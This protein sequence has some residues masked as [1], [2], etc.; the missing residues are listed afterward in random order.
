[1][2]RVAELNKVFFKLFSKIKNVHVFF[3]KV[4]P[5]FFKRWGALFRNLH[6][7]RMVCVCECRT[8]WQYRAPAVEVI[9]VV[10]SAP[11]EGARHSTRYPSHDINCYFPYD[12]QC[13]ALL[14]FIH[15]AST[16]GWRDDQATVVSVHDLGFRS[17]LGSR[18]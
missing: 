6:P 11:A 2:L 10:G 1:M 17:T 3:R 5:T 4:V 8:D 9:G 18:N 13:T 16:D 7:Q 15:N 14:Y 12:W